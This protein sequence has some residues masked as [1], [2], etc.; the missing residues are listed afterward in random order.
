MNPQTS[1]GYST[2]VQLSFDDAVQKTIELLKEQGFGILTTIDVKAKMKE[3][4][5]LDMEDYLILGACN[6]KLAAHA[7]QAEKEV[8][9]LMPCNVLVY[10]HKDQTRVSAQLPSTMMSVTGN[11]LVC[12]V[13]D[14]AEQTLK[15]VIDQLSKL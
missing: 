6:P 14:Q 1:Y 7:L 9:L 4:M 3:K 10:Q 13:A 2:T 11:K 12:E 8:G 15:K 5:N